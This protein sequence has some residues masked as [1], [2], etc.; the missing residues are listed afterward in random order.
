MSGG[1]GGASGFRP[2]ALTPFSAEEAADDLLDFVSRPDTRFGTGWSID[3][4]VGMVGVGELALLWARTSCGKSTW[5]LNLV[6]NTPDIPTVVFNMEMTPR[7]QLEWLAAM[8]FPLET[9]GRDIENVL[10][11]GPDDNRYDETMK[12]VRG[13]RDYYPNLHFVNPSRPT[14]ED[15]SVVLEDIESMTGTRP[16]RVFIDHMTLMRGATDYSGVVETAS[17][18]HSWAMADNVAVYCLQQTGRGGNDG[19]RGVRNDGHIPVTLSSG[20]YAG[21][22][23]ADWIYGLYRPDRHPKFKR[24]KEDFDSITAWFD[25]NDELESVRGL[26]VFQVLKNRPYGETLESG[27]EFHY[28]G[29]TRTYNELGLDYP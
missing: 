24:R 1:N 27:I 18:L 7:R 12:A 2:G 5:T 25:M 16:Q 6:H 23:D 8:T 19:E 9:P 11:F 3:D 29:H 15:F 10:R 26:V 22:H 13:V 4:T 28:D 14:V 20:L 17:K 21:E